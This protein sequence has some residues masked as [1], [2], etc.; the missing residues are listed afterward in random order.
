[1]KNNYSAPGSKLLSV[2]LLLCIGSGAFA[3]VSSDGRTGNVIPTGVPFLLVSPDPRSSGMG[4][5]GVALEDD[6]NATF[7]N[8]SKMVFMKSN[9]SVSLSY[10]PW[11]RN[12]VSDANISY[13]NFQAKTDDR[14]AIGVSMRYFNLGKIDLA[15]ANNTSQGAYS[16]YEYAIDASLARSFGDNFSLGFT[17][18]YI[19]SHIFNSDANYK[20]QAG[21]SVGADLSLFY[22]N[23]FDL[24]GKESHFSFGTDISN[25]GSEISYDNTIASQSFLPANLKLGI[26]NTWVLD[27]ENELTLAVDLNKLLVP[28]PPQTDSN[29]RI[30]KGK[31]TDVSVPAGIFGSF[32]DAPGGFSEELQEINYSAGLEYAFNHRFFLRTGYFYENPNKGN[33]QYATFGVGYKYDFMDFNFS[34]LAASQQKTPLAN[35][36]RFG[37]VFNLGRK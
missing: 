26:A 16:P 22:R 20:L 8:P 34:Y 29:G 32:S 10:C 27:N 4:D 36:L 37:I 12:L 18:R 13:L 5:A 31:S 9:S 6:A 1:M 28:T 21:S 19:S 30:I 35:T 17:I 15:D 25:I 23:K 24:F 11:L 14:T 3:Q 33:R 2:M 7:W